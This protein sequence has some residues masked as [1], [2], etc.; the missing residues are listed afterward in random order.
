MS[1]QQR[2]PTYGAWR[3]PQSGGA[4][5]ASFAATI[6]T[7]GAAVVVILA[8]AL[9]RSLLVTG[10]LIAA[11]AAV[12]VPMLVS[13]DGLSGTRRLSGWRSSLLS[14]R[15]GEDVY[16]SGAFSRVPGGLLR[17]PGVL[18]GTELYESIDSDG[19]PFAMIHMPDKHLYTVPLAAEPQ[20]GE[21]FD[22]VH[23]D[24]A[25]A[26]WGQQLTSFT[27]TGD[28]PLV[29]AV[30]DTVPDTGT[31]LLETVRARVRRDA[32]LLAR[33]SM[34]E[35]ATGTSKRGIRLAARL[36][37]T[38]EAQTA[39]RRRDPAE[40]AVEIATRL[41]DITRAAA[42]AGVICTP[43][44]ADEIVGTVRRSYDPA[45]LEAVE[46][47]LYSGEGT[48]QSWADAGPRTHFRK[49]DRYFHESAVSVTWEMRVAPKRAVPERV[50][51]RLIRPHPELPY[52]RVAIVYRPHKAAEGADVADSDYRNAAARR[53][54][55]TGLQK[56]ADI[57]DERAANLVQQEQALGHGLTRFAVLITVT[58]P[59]GRTELIPRMN[60]ILRDISTQA[61]L[62]VRVSK[63]WQDAAFAVGLGVGVSAPDHT[64]LPRLADG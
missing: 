25:V 56:Q 52:K 17:L 8:F 34:Y 10:L 33:Q 14:R 29:V 15:R 42:A 2:P 60:A 54:G 30:L 16:S 40:Q 19:R 44:T 48:G 7:M 36:S 6:L 45:A 12:L 64:S 53:T 31:V 62:E 59:D 37:I 5:G 11:S 41:G 61:L 27:T 49:P 63:H 38:F 1:T 26:N 35:T 24:R 4:F 3:R 51:E 58:E 39:D 23:L 43:M 20:G 18:A 28:I 46:A 9:T 13:D 22:Q 50:L 47:A 32:P 21:N 57:N 55:R